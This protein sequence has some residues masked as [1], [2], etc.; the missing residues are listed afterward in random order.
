MKINNFYQSKSYIILLLIFVSTNFSL[1]AV[2]IY[3]TGDLKSNGSGSI[4]IV[5]SANEDELKANKFTIGNFHFSEEQAR[6]QFT[7]PNTNVKNVKLDFDQKESRY[8]ITVDVDFKD[9]NKLS[10]ARG[11]S[12]VKA[13][14]KSTDT[15]NVFRYI[16]LV[17]PELYKKFSSQSYIMNFESKVKSSNGSIKGNTVTWGNRS[18]D[19]SDF[20]KDVYLTA[21]TES[22]GKL[23]ESKVEGE[24]EKSCGLF[25][26]ELPLILAGAYFY[27]NKFRKK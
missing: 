26:I 18:K 10:D 11:F 21:T 16:I 19:N 27:S 4:K 25:G 12:N 1:G 3:Q 5:Y 23:N 17:N 13:S 24:Q 14:Y 9:I 22:D 8:F 2:K 20:S 7:S 15:G 6:K